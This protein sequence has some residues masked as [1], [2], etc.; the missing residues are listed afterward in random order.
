M[1]SSEKTFQLKKLI[2]ENLKPLIDNNYVLLELPYYSNV[3]DL[4]IWKGEEYFLEGL[5]HKCLMRKSFHTF[6][7]PE[8]DNN[9]IILL[10]GGGNWGDI[11]SGKDTPHFFRKEIVRAYPNNKIIVFPQ[12]IHY[13]ETDNLC[14]DSELFSAHKNLTICVRDLVSYKI[15]VDNFKN[16]CLLLPDMAFCI[17]LEFIQKYEK[18]P[19]YKYLFLKRNDAELSEVDYTHYIPERQYEVKDWP[20][21]NPNL[22]INKILTYILWKKKK[23]FPDFLIDFYFQKIHKDLLIRKGIQFVSSYEKVYTTRLHVAI[24]SVLLERK[25]VFFDNSY[26]KNFNYY[27]QWLVDLSTVKFLKK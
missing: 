10:Q 11:W 27:S 19:T 9:V 5:T 17:P 2:V 20:M 6:S 12:T 18:K 8:L 25:F 15:V 3:G 4:L 24:L 21:M 14:K 22:N 23:L 16:N 7:F 13:N 1:K 26:G